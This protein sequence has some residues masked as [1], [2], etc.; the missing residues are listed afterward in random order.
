MNKKIYIVERYAIGE[1]QPTIVVY[2]C[3]SLMPI[4]E[5]EKI[6]IKIAPPFW[7]V[8]QASMTVI[9]DNMNAQLE[10]EKGEVYRVKITQKVPIDL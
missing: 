1:K 10:G 5:Q 9:Y 6:K 2:T 8:S 3:A 4:I 7:R